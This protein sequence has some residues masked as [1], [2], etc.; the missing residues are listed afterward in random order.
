MATGSWSPKWAPSAPA[1]GR[2][3]TLQSCSG[4]TSELRSD[5]QAEARPT[6]QKAEPYATVQSRYR[7]VL[8][9]VRVVAFFQVHVGEVAG[10]SAGAQ[11]REGEPQPADHVPV[12]GTVAG[13]RRGGRS[14]EHTSELQSLRHLV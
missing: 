14:E 13:D 2:C 10:V 8:G 12:P 6:R 1:G 11:H 4:K 9:L 5:W 7:G 3:P